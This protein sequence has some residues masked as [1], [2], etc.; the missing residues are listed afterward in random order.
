[1]ILR[2]E[3]VVGD[4]FASPQLLDGCFES[5]GGGTGGDGQV[6]GRPTR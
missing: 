1:V 5:S 3:E 4:L 6:F 2:V